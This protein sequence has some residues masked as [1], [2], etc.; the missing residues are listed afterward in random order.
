MVNIAKQV[1]RKSLNLTDQDVLGIDCWSHVT[2]LA[3]QIAAEAYEVG[4]DAQISYLDDGLWR[5]WFEM[6]EKYIARKSPISGA[7]AETITAYVSLWG[8]ED[9]S[10]FDRSKPERMAKADAWIKEINDRQ[11][12]RKVRS[13]FLGLAQVTPQRARK[14]GVN[15]AKWKRI[16]NASLGADLK[17][18]AAHGRLVSKKRIGC[19]T[20]GLNPRAS[21]LGGLVD[22]FVAGAVTIGLGGNQDIGGANRSSFDFGATLQ[23]ATVT[24]DGMSVVEAGK[25]SK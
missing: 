10:V 7:L 22:H 23:K 4:A 11:R 19:L 24:A 21:Y 15:F 25:L 14:Y 8:P 17:P 13:L 20:I 1:V 5:S 6:D 12:E 3:S 16:I 2:G 18:I 9:P